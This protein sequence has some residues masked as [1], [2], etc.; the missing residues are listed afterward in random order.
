MGVAVVTASHDGVE[1][2]MT[3]SSLT[4]VSAE[5]S[6]ISVSLNKSGHEHGLVINPNNFAVTI[7]SDGQKKDI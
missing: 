5:P 1:H 7:L 6:S 2:G 3:V 4:S